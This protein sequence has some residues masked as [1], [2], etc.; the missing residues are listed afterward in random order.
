MA[1]EDICPQCQQQDCDCSP[2]IVSEAERRQT[3]GEPPLV[4]ASDAAQV[5]KRAKTKER[6]E[7]QD[8]RDLNW[9]MR[10]EQGRRIMWDLLENSGL[11]RNPAFDAGFEPNRTM[12]NAGQMN[13]GQ[14]YL[15]RV[16]ELEPDGYNLM[17]KE[18]SGSKT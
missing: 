1:T 14:F 3:A 10:H 5:S 18:N 4:I 9:L 16:T 2:E 8:A 15:Q 7:K 13:L 12:F 6:G 17:V 11:Y